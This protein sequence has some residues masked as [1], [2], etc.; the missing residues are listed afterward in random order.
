MT[1]FYWNDTEQQSI[2][3]AAEKGYANGEWL[4]IDE[5]VKIK[6]VNVLNYRAIY[7]RTGVRE[8]EQEF[9]SIQRR[10]C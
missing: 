5:L 2:D 1:K 8:L 10:L 7:F 4:W 3:D 6:G 9:A